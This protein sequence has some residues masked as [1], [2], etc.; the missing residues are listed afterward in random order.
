MYVPDTLETGQRH[1]IKGR[2]TKTGTSATKNCRGPKPNIVSVTI[3]T[4]S[5]K[6]IQK[7]F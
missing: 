3:R 2:T 5:K 6:N 4:R 7:Q 1:K